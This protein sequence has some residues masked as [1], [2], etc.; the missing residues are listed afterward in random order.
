MEAC[1]RPV[2]S[3]LLRR[4]YAVQDGDQ[5]V[6]PPCG[7]EGTLDVIHRP[8]GCL[9][10]SSDPSRQLSLPPVCCGWT[11]VSI[12]SPLLWPLHSPSGIYQVHGSC[13][14]YPSRHGCSDTLVSGLL[15]GPHLIQIRSP[16]DKVLN[17]CHQLGIVVNHAQSHLIPSHSVTYLIPSHSVTYLIPSHSVTYLIPSHSVT[18]LG[19]YLEIS[20]LSAFSS[21]ERILTLI[22]QLDEFLSCR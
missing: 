1:G 12:Q 16:V 4:T 18:Y 19:M 21:Q 22:S 10:T 9:L 20:S 6:S 17:L 11:G 14:S 15:V 13:V 7:T 2:T 5:P 3:Q 8:Q